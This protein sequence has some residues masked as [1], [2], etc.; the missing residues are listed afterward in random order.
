[1]TR[2]RGT[3]RREL[4]IAIGAGPGGLCMGMRLKA[5]GFCQL[6]RFSHGGSW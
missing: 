5:A 1:M 6:A 2:S 3:R 4:R